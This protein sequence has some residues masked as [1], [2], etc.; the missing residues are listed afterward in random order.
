MHRRVSCAFEGFRSFLDEGWFTLIYDNCADL[1]L[2]TGEALEVLVATV[3]RVVKIE[4]SALKM[5]AA[6]FS[7]ALVTKRTRCRT[8]EY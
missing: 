3:F 1:Q 4:W 2:V 6:S 5:G 8:P 7:C